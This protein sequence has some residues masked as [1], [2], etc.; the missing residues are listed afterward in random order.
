[1]TF[2]ECCVACATATG[3]SREDW[4]DFFSL[5]PSAQQAAAQAYKDQDWYQKGGSVPAA[6]LSVLLAAAQV[7]GAASGIGTAFNVLRAL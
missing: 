1:M 3:M 5:S 7:A 4:A 6:L 2:D